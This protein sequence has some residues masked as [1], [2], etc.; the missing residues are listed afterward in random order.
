MAKA[1]T[2]E[3]KALIDKSKTID[4]FIDKDPDKV[5]FIGIDRSLVSTGYAVV[6]AGK[7][8]DRGSIK[9]G[10]YGAVRLIEIGRK[11]IKIAKSYSPVLICMENYA[12]ARANQAHQLGEL[13]GVVKV[14][15]TLKDIKWFDV[16]PPAVKKYVI[17]KGIGKKNLMLAN[18]FKKWN[19]MPTNDDEADAIGI[20]FLCYNSFKSLQDNSSY[21]LNDIEC[22][23]TLLNL[24]KNEKKKT[25]KQKNKELAK[26]INER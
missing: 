21:T 1:L 19:I 14:F 11:I 3:D 23:N 25:Q 20:A 6:R 22:F 13:G 8:I 12:F 15:L 17:G 10:S 18:V 7:V 9:S 26:E 4:L 2:Q 24:E 16:S 5:T